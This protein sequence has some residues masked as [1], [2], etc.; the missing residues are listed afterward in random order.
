MNIFTQ[1]TQ[2]N[3]AKM[4]TNIIAFAMR[5]E[6]GSLDLRPHRPVYGWLNGSMVWANHTIDLVAAKATKAYGH[7]GKPAAYI[8][9][10]TGY[11]AVTDRMLELLIKSVGWDASFSWEALTQEEYDKQWDAY[12][13]S[14]LWDEFHAIRK[15]VGL[16]HLSHNLMLA[17]SVTE[18]WNLLTDN[19]EDYCVYSE[20]T[21]DGISYGINYLRQDGSWDRQNVTNIGTLTTKHGAELE[22][23]EYTNNFAAI[24]AEIAAELEQYNHPSP[25]GA[26]PTFR[27]S[28]IGTDYPEQAWAEFHQEEADFREECVVNV[29]Q[30]LSKIN[31]APYL[32]RKALDSACE[33]VGGLG[34]TT[35]RRI[36]VGT[37]QEYYQCSLC[38]K[39][40]TESVG[41]VTP[42]WVLCNDCVG[43][44]E[45]EAKGYTHNK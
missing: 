15:M 1:N 41:S 9:T 13:D 21:N 32:R 11:Q 34:R 42:E 43:S 30:I 33:E 22:L 8:A 23:H 16:D 37:D 26:G 24:V 38:G 31:H 17:P 2:D 18:L 39:L 12:Q 25:L 5:G 3:L 27:P 4:V 7:E 29:I 14:L 36:V 40:T 20:L 28:D 19:S 35:Y 44:P 45:A 10:E 6:S